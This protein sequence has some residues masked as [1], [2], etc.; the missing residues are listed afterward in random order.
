MQS[1]VKPMFLV[2]ERLYLRPVERGDLAQIQA[3]S[4]DAELRALTGETEPMSEAGVE[5]YYQRMQTERD[6]LWLAV[7]LRGSDRLIGETGL[8]RMFHPWRT[9]DCSLVLGDRAAWGQG[10][11][12]EALSLLLDHTFGNLNFHRV[13]VGVA[14]GNTRALRFWEKAGF[15]REGVQRDGYYL[16]HC[17]ADFVMLSLLEDE[18][19]ALRAGQTARQPA[20]S[21]WGG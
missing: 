11:G 15:R 12:R 20:T 1:N 18:Y 21:A 8:L 7:V 14:A 5:A 17:Y 2:G 4:N 9:T 3:W 16:N 19:R 6:R 13:A 10:F